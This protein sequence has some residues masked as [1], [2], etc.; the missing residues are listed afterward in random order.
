MAAYPTQLDGQLG[1]ADGLGHS[2]NHVLELHDVAAETQRSREAESCAQ[3]ERRMRTIDRSLNLLLPSAVAVTFINKFATTQAGS[4]LY[5]RHTTLVAAPSF[6]FLALQG[7]MDACFFIPPF[8][9]TAVIFGKWALGTG[10]GNNV[11]VR[12]RRL[13]NWPQHVRARVLSWLDMLFIFFGLS[14]AVQST[15]WLFGREPL[16]AT[17]I[18]VPGLVLVV[19]INLYFKMLFML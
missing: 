13:H 16:L 17:S 9:V 15:C 14:Q 19:A 1:A 4:R 3:E 8:I 12:R 11:Q 18:L 7:V 5:P 10:E 6:T 2:Q